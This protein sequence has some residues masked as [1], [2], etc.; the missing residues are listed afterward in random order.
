LTK[1]SNIEIESWVSYIKLTD[2]AKDIF[3]RRLSVKLTFRP[4]GPGPG[5]AKS[6]QEP[7]P[8]TPNGI[9]YNTRLVEAE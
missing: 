3:L 6:T 7:I 2:Q 9:R 4:C 5:P 8:T 1:S